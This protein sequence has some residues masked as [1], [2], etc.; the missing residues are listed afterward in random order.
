[1]TLALDIVKSRFVKELLLLTPGPTTVPQD[2]LDVLSRPMI[3]HRSGEFGRDLALARTGLNE[4]CDCDGESVV[5]TS[6]GTG[7]M[8]ATVACL[9]GPRDEVLVVVAGKFGQRWEALARHYELNVK[10]LEIKW[11]E[12]V[13]VDQVMMQLSQNTRAVLIQGCE[14]STG[15]CHPIEALGK[16]LRSRPEVLFIVDGIT[17]VGVHD[18]SM[19]K[20]NVDVMISGSQKA[21]MC[22]PGLA[23]VSLSQ[24]ALTRLNPKPKTYYFNL[25]KELKNQM[26]NKTAYTPA[27]SLVQALTVALDRM[28][29]EGLANVYKR[30]QRLSELTR[31]A[32]RSL[33]FELFNSDQDAA[34]GL[35]AVKALPGQDLKAWLKVL[36]TDHG[37]WLAGGQDAL[38]GKIFRLAHMGYCDLSMLQKAF[39]IM[40]QTLSNGQALDKAGSRVLKENHA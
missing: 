39:D 30:H 18:F 33:G 34:H 4:V 23:F 17:S 20:C 21:L 11:G 7:A 14:T 2:V 10:V 37:L 1:M 25:S 19:K 36:K 8:E 9:F 26:E 22:P 3:H 40:E 13:N 12:A 15:V 6:S 31:K 24:K 5:L 38:E 35:T 32:F 28:K 16:A 29:K 27:L